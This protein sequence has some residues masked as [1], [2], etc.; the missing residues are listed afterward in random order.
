[1]RNQIMNFIVT[2]EYGLWMIENSIVTDAFSINIGEMLET[3]KG[4]KRVGW[5]YL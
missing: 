1:M 3:E 5:F 2:D 4:R